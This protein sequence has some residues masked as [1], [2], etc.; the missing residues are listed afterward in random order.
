MTNI[1]TEKI[2]ALVTALTGAAAVF[3]KKR[4]NR[5]RPSTINHRGQ[6]GSDQSTVVTQSQL[7]QSLDTMRDRITESYNTMTDKFA[8]HQRE[9]L[10]AIGTQGT[11]IEKRLDAL[12]S[13]VARLDER[14]SKM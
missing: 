9:I 8:D 10:S 4:Y 6:S 13:T 1:S 7:H 11:A 14:T 3:I 12:E 2:T 5:S